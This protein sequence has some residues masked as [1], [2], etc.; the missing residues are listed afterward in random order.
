LQF[1]LQQ[2][3]VVVA[4][5]VGAIFLLCLSFLSMGKCILYHWS[6]SFLLCVSSLC[7]GHANPINIYIYILNEPRCTSCRAVCLLLWTSILFLLLCPSLFRIPL[8]RT[9]SVRFPFR[10]P[11]RSHLFFYLR[12]YLTPLLIAPSSPSAATFIGRRHSCT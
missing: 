10:T 12:S 5:I 7:G 4:D 1:L 3:L 9:R 8:L 11:P 2:L 6:V